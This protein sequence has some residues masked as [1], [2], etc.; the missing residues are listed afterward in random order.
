MNVL[1]WKFR[2]ANKITTVYC[3]YFFKVLLRKYNI[4]SYFP[5]LQSLR[6]KAK[7]CRQYCC[8]VIVQVQSVFFKIKNVSVLKITAMTKFSSGDIYALGLQ[9]YIKYISSLNFLI[10]KYQK[11]FL[12][13]M[14]HKLNESYL[15]I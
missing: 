12:Y 10:W 3:Y 8:S 11:R 1:K 5:R 7:L 14:L 6:G 2:I 4:T 9:I 13:A 15:K